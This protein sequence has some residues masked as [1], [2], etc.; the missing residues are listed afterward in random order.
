ML[1]RD[2][3]TIIEGKIAG[4]R[5]MPEDIQLS[6]D[7]YEALQ[8]VATYTTPRVLLRN[9][10]KDVSESTFRVIEECAYITMPDRPIFDTTNKEYSDV[11]HLN[12]DEDLVFAVIYYT[13][14][15]IMKGNEPTQVGG[16]K[17]T[18][19]DKAKEL[20]N[21]YQS[22]FTRAGSEILDVM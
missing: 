17:K 11:K 22:N 9:S 20:I 4:T 1:I 19:E 15:I 5:P 2:V 13:L 7:V 3:K 16:N 8:Y 21:V 12:I 6:F 18:F 10:E 14:H